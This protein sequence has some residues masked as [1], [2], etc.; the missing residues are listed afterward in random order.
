MHGII[1]NHAH[2][3]ESLLNTRV[4]ALFDQAS[5]IIILV[6][7]TFTQFYEKLLNTQA[8]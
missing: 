8:Q 2:N 4:Q 5:Y 1:P 7:S 3:I 6:L